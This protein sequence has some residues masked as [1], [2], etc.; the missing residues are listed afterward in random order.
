MILALELLLFLLAFLAP[1]LIAL[2]LVVTRIRTFKAFLG[3]IFITL[4]ETALVIITASSW[5]M[6]LFSQHNYWGGDKGYGFDLFFLFFYLPSAGFLGDV[7]GAAI[8]VIFYLGLAKNCRIGQ[9]DLLPCLVLGV[10]VSAVLAGLLAT[11][12]YTIWYDSLFGDDLYPARDLL[13]LLY[14]LLGGLVAGIISAWLGG[15]AMVIFGQKLS[16]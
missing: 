13:I 6:A 4:A 10:V 15:K 14:V 11:P 12:L 7:T 3:T 16:R 2:I 9:S 5:R 8:A 1:G